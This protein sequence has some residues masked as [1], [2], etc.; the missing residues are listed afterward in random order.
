[1]LWTEL[2]CTLGSFQLTGMQQLVFVD[3]FIAEWPN[4]QIVTGAEVIKETGFSQVGNCC[5]RLKSEGNISNWGK[6]K[7][8]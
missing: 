3:G 8:R 7:F 1:M 4:V 6:T 2:F 5:T